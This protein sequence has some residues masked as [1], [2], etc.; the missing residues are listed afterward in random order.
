[1]CE[2]LVRIAES[3]NERAIF[4][5]EHGTFH[6]SWDRALFYISPG[7]L[8]YLHSLF[9]KEKISNKTH[10]KY[11]HIQF[12]HRTAS[13][14]HIY[15]ELWIEESGMKL[16]FEDCEIL[17]GLMYEV[18]SWQKKQPALTSREHTRMAKTPTNKKPYWN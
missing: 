11:E 8:S 13:D 9:S 15:F 5:C 3:S 7:E 10:A 16:S 18:L 4:R 6:L 2:Y 12:F 1:M 17:K 14:G